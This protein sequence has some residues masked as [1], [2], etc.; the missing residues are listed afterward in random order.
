MDEAMRI[1]LTRARPWALAALCVGAI[2]CA[3]TGAQ[4]ARG[5]ELA[6]F[7]VDPDNAE[8]WVDD[9]YRGRIDGWRDGAV[10]LKTG[11]R[12]IEIR[13][14]GHI[15]RRLDLDVEPD[16]ELHVEIRLT[17]DPDSIEWDR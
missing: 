3:T 6:T 7:A 4:R 9:A 12:R 2:G 13:A 5:S 17:P 14:P 15:T 1:D 10:P 16:E 8:I 11:R